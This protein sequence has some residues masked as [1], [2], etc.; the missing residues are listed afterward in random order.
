MNKL[1]EKI[2]TIKGLRKGKGCK[3]S[4]IEEAQ[5]E[6][7]ITFPEEFIDYVKNY[8]CID[9]GSVEWTGLNINGYLNTVTATKE[10]ADNNPKFPK[11]HFVLHDLGIDSKKVIVGEDGKV[12]L[13]QNS[14]IVPVCNSILEYL[15]LCISSQ[16]D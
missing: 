16:Q 3:T 8:G 15:E 12:F 2:N 14:T 1:I 10:E 13:I 5:K 9:F 6:L 11:K 7:D 4:Q